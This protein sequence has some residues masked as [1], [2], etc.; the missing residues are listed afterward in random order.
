MTRSPF[1][2]DVAWVSPWSSDAGW[3]GVC[4]YNYLQCRFPRPFATF[5]DIRVGCGDF[6]AQGVAE[7][8]N[9][10][11]EADRTEL[12]RFQQKSGES[13]EGSLP[14]VCG[15]GDEMEMETGTGTETE[16][17][18]APSFPHQQNSRFVPCRPL[19]SLP[20]LVLRP[21]R[22]LHS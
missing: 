3:P 20:R 4:C 6:A 5:V 18:D 11:G 9:L 8:G 15:G 1:A 21:G 22:N 12:G 2:I 10:V 13:G 16:M 7:T 19:T 17:G 14:L